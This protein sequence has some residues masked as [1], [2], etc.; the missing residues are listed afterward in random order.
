MTCAKLH[1]LVQ[2]AAVM[3]GIDN[4]MCAGQAVRGVTEGRL[5]L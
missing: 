3:Q 1:R 2:A 4:G 5:C